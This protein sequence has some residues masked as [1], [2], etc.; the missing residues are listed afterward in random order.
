M[1]KY[2][3]LEEKINNLKNQIVNTTQSII[4]KIQVEQPDRILLM[5]HLGK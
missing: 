5:H 3:E 4:Q 2:E 1:S